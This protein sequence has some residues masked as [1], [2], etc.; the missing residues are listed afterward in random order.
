MINKLDKFNLKDASAPKLGIDLSSTSSATVAT[1]RIGFGFSNAIE[2]LIESDFEQV[3]S[4]V[5]RLA[6]KEVRGVGRIEVA[7]LFFQKNKDLLA[8][9]NQ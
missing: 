4:I 8:K 5:E 1:P 7:R 9:L 2:L 6:A 3:A